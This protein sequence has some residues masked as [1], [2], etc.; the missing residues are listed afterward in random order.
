MEASFHYDCANRMVKWKSYYF[1]EKLYQILIWL[2]LKKLS[3]GDVMT[4][5]IVEGDVDAFLKL[6][7]VELTAGI[8]HWSK[9]FQ[10]NFNWRETGRWQKKS[11]FSVFR[12][13][14]YVN[15]HTLAKRTLWFRSNCVLCG[16]WTGRRY[17]SCES[18]S[19]R[20][21]CFQSLCRR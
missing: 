14:W 11:S 13:A 15:Y 12:W 10:I 1:L 5:V 8:K 18:K 7:K 19:H 17:G 6:R 21:W 20:I 2:L 9:I 3:N 16:C 4:K